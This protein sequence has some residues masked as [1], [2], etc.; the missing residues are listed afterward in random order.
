[1]GLFDK[2]GL[3]RKKPR[4][5]GQKLEIGRE[6]TR[7]VGGTNWAYKAGILLV[8]VA[9]T[10]AAFPRGDLY[11]YT[12]EV[13]EEW[14]LE[15]L[16]APFD[17]PIYKS[18]SELE[19]EREAVRRRSPPYFSEVVDAQ[20][21][22][23]T[24]RNTVAQQLETV[25]QA[26]EDY[27]LN[28]L[29]GRSAEA[30]R[31]S[32]AYIEYRRA[33]RLKAT[34][35]QWQMLVDSYAARVPDL[36][37]ASREPPEGPRLDQQLLADAWEI[38]TQLLNVG[39][40]DVTLDSVQA[41][42]VL[43]R[44]E[45]DHL[46]RQKSKDNL[47]GLNEAYTYAQSRFQQIYDDSPAV[48]NLGTAF[49]RAIFVPS[50]SYLRG[51]TVR[52][53]QRRESRI[54]VTRGKVSEGE[55][56]VD[57][58]QRVTDEIHRKL[59]S[60]EQA[61]RE[62]GADDIL[63]RVVLGQTLICLAT[64][65][66]FFLYLYLLR[67]TIFDD[68]RRIMLVA[69][70]FAGIIGLFA[71]SLR[72]ETL[73]MYIVPVAIAPVLFTV[74]FDSRVGLFGALTLSLIGGLLLNYDFEFTFAT[75]FATTLGVFSVRDIRN[76]GQFFISSGLVFL[77]Y[78]VVL[79]STAI[80]FGA[81][82][83]LFLA[84][85]LFVGVNSFLLIMAY[86]LLWV[87]ERAFDITTDLSLLELSDT[88]RPLLKELSMRAPGT[89]NH[90]L[91]VANLAEA[92]ADA[93]GANA[94]LTRVGAL[95]HDIGKMLKPEYFV[96]NQRPGTNP[97]TQLKP[98]MSALIIA[99]HV[100]EGL[101]M[102]RQYNLPQRVLDFIPMH[103]GTTRIEFFYRKA[104]DQRN[105]GDPE[106]LESE[107]RYP[108]PRPDS[109]ETGILML[110]DSVEA[111]SRS[112]S[113]P[114]HKRLE[115]L[116][117][118]IFKARTEDGQLDKTDLTFRDLN[119]IRETFLSMLLGIYH[120][121]VKYPG[122]ESDD[123]AVA[124]ARD[125]SAQN[126]PIASS[127]GG[128]PSTMS[129]IREKGVYGTMEQS[130]SAAE[131]GIVED[132]ED[133]ERTEEESAAA[134]EGPTSADVTSPDAS[135]RAEAG[136][137]PSGD[138]QAPGTDAAEGEAAVAPDES[139]A[140]EA[141]EAP[142]GSG[143]E[144]STSAPVAATTRNAGISGD[145]ASSQ[146]SNDAPPADA[147]ERPTSETHAD[148]TARKDEI[149]LIN[150][151]ILDAE[152]KEQELRKAQSSDGPTEEEIENRARNTAAEIQGN[153]DARGTGDEADDKAQAGED[154]GTIPP[155]GDGA[156]EEAEVDDK[157]KDE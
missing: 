15:R 23:A 64:Y 21:R 63:W 12:T 148:D 55:L 19:S 151:E 112:L 128:P 85:L 123:T 107:F 133:A 121:R 76:R 5:V 57:R 117:D 4:P 18:Q 36:P 152:A 65:F 109:K 142:H 150:D 56:I 118:M 145:A 27:Q 114:T 30:R 6:P 138:R 52:E 126:E 35:E 91:Q 17:F 8:L 69:I 101:E 92:A 100:K 49:F 46:E 13:G 31:D 67:R 75:I 43:I 111:A 48:A 125:E 87:F 135:E 74:M 68:N 60:L 2:I 115:T 113:D 38:G 84:D 53:W 119:Q 110:A 70:L 131:D 32:V 104:L 149:L 10:L 153:G 139:G 106:I 154:G 7:R 54:S 22:M 20:E 116:I 50:L 155:N 58:G 3:A 157:K 47:Y 136:G 59:V 45:I 95:Y 73:A 97:H 147:D 99:S 134:A 62:P 71:V 140:S 77:G 61:R 81:P 141:P 94:L 11:Q 86:P 108:G 132:I 78:V 88:N 137:L 102:G 127:P 14:R 1:M 79:G 146:T 103:H 144:E 98:R 156:A 34:P 96:E 80:Y 82:R 24:N 83:D 39:V 93:V 42:Q 129:R 29:R 9:L 120:V 44:N 28:R 143:E 124:A 33:A 105:E 90:S 51:D 26:Y 41:E 37:Q 122:Q 40:M 89:F 130:V 72:V 16:E 25:F 66:I